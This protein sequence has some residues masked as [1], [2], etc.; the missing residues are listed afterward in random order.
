MERMQSTWEHVVEHD[1]SES[2]VRPLSADEL[3]A[4]DPDAL[5]RL[6]REPLGYAQ[7]NGHEALREVIASFYPG[8]S[9][10]GVCVTTGT[11]EANFLALMAL[12]EPGDRVVVVLPS[13]MQVHG[14]A[15]GLGAEVVPVWL[16]ESRRWQ[17]DPDAL[18]RAVRGAKVVYV[19]DPNNPTGAVMDE[20]CR[21]ALRQIV[22]DSGAWLVADEVYRGAE[23][24]GS[25]TPSV[26]A[27]DANLI[28]TAGLSKAFGLPG[29][30]IG[31]AVTTP[32]MATQI[33]SYHDYTTIAPT[34]LSAA[35][36]E[37][38]VRQRER[39]FGRTR[40]ILRENW[41]VLEAWAEAQALGVVPPAAGAIAFFRAELP[42]AS[43]AFVDRL[44]REKNAMIVPGDHFLMDGYL[45]IGFGMTSAQLEVGLAR[46]AELLQAVRVPL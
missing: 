44:I 1:L 32:E 14:W 26:F 25:L 3:F 23:R 15:R 40:A 28:V 9:P 2:G 35:F 36:A 24:I 43:S 8:A 12:V 30:R 33:W 19:C 39:L 31:W 10:D 4:D 34:T 20:S 21:R 6:L 37:H 18:R 17:L 7:G 22:A 42:S 38:A 5:A 13:Y 45:R 41:P 29:L 16:E 46:V 11:S 27:P